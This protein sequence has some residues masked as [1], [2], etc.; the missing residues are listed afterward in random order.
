MAKMK[1]KEIFFMISFEKN[2]EDDD[3]PEKNLDW[4][5]AIENA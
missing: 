1:Q 5:F 2:S 3:I 4:V